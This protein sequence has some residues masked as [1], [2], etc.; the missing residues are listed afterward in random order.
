MEPRHSHSIACAHMFKQVGMDVPL[1]LKHRPPMP[2]QWNTMRKINSE[3]MVPRT[4]H[5]TIRT[6]MLQRNVER[7][8]TYTCAYADQH[9]QT[10]SRNGACHVMCACH[11]YETLCARVCSTFQKLKFLVSGLGGQGY[12]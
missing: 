12:W 8:T 11:N 4:V 6:Y 1:V 7:F 10:C 2:T 5:S 3:A 9:M